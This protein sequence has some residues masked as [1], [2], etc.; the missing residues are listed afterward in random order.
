VREVLTSPGQP[1]DSATRGF[2]ERR[3]GRDLCDIR[4]HTDEDAAKSAQAVNAY[5]YTVGHHVVF[6]ANQ[7]AP[8]TEDG[9]HLL[10]H[11]L[12]HSI[13]QQ[14]HAYQPDA[15][16]E[17]ADSGGPAESEAAQT[18]RAWRQ[19]NQPLSVMRAPAGPS[20][21]AAAPAVNDVIT[22]ARFGA[23]LRCQRAYERLAGIGP[24]PP[25]GREEPTKLRQ[26]QLRI[27]VRKIFGTDLDMDQ[28][29]EIVGEMRGRLTPGLAVVRAPANDKECGI[30][31]AYVVGLNPPIHLCPAFFA[32]TPEDQI[33]TMIHEAAHLSGIGSAALGE[34]Y[35]VIFDCETSCGGFDSA[36]S[37]AHFVNCA[38]GAPVEEPE[39][40]GEESKTAK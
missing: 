22:S 30:R 13:Q 8:A 24:P 37:W 14:L 19:L 20:P 4:V 33:R 12:T 21:L 9:R 1:L 39:S 15:T 31:A 11:E 16:L 18:S 3:F 29:T 36:D 2:M 23:F 26:L 32:G 27:L 7:Y 35:C 10:A 40:E 25:P 6:G 38:S 34:S 5:A 17:I 28:V